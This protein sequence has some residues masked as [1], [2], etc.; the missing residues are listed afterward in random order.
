MPRSEFSKKVRVAAFAR[1]KGFCEGP[2]C[3]T[4]LQTGKFAYDHDIPDGLGGEP[5][6]ENCVLL[7]SACHSAKSG[8]RDIPMI[9]KAKRVHAA[10]IGARPPSVRPMPGGRRSKWKRK[11][12]GEIVL[13]D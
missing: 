10:H 6:L 7:C 4:R 3:G 5:T 9:A 1:S 2:G 13:R 12:N 8:K 11:M